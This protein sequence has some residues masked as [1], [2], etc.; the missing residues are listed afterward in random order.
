VRF[1]REQYIELMTFGYCERWI[2]ELFGMMAGLEKEWRMQG[3]SSDEINL[4]AFDWDYVPI[5]DCGGTTGFFGG[6]KKKI[7]EETEEYVI[8]KDELGRRLKLFKSCATIPLPLDYPVDDWESWQKIKPLLEFSEG[9]IDRECV[10]KARRLQKEGYLVAAVIPGGFDYPRRLMG[11]ENACV[12][13]HKQPD[14]MYDIINTI[15]DTAYRVLERV[16]DMVLIDHLSVAEDLAGNSGPIISPKIAE[17]FIKP[18]YLKM[19]EMLSAKGTKIFNI[20]TDGN[21]TVIMDIL[22]EAGI[23][24]MNPFEAAAGMDIVEIR[25][26][27]G[28]KLAMKGGINK[29]VLRENRGAILRELEYKMQPCM[30]SGGIAFGLDHRIPDGTPLEHYR[31]YVDTGREILGLPPRDPESMGWRRMAF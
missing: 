23:N 19:W 24:S 28:R 29:F 13:Y 3:A 25:K 5:I 12:S 15:T 8:E 6:E 31:Y 30:Q 14:L 26:K 9:R 22:L 16:S 11:A 27:Y 2:I 18:Y 21:V 7:L 20:D 1:S 17:T 10:E 4:T